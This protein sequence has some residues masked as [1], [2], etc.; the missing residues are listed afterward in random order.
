[1]LAELF[2]TKRGRQLASVVGASVLIL[3]GIHYYYRIKATKLEIEHLEEENKK[4]KK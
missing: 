3:S 1:M 4:D 2:K